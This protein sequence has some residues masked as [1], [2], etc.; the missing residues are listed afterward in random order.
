MGQAFLFKA[1]Y[2]TFAL[3]LATCFGVPSAVSGL[4][5]LPLSLG[6]LVRPLLLGS[7]FD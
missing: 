4:D 5:L 6:S 3:A 1:V 2:V 7:L